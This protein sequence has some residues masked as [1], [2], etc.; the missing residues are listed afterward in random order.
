MKAVKMYKLS[1]IR[2]IGMMDVM[3][4]MIS[5][6]QHCCMLYMKV[7]ESKSQEFS[8]QIKFFSISLILCLYEMMDVHWTYDNHFMMYVSQINVLYTLNLYSAV[9]Q[10]YLN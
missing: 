7:V 5:K 8:P 4:N 2:Q 6:Q 3:F 10:L 9:C 1:V